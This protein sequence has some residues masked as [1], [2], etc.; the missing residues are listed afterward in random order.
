MKLSNN[1]VLQNEDIFWCI[2]LYGNQITSPMKRTKS[3]QL[4]PGAKYL[5]LG[6]SQKKRG[7]AILEQQL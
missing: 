6:S 7:G 2:H 5:G 4:V 1:K 3:Y